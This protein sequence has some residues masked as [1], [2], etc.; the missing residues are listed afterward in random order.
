MAARTGPGNGMVMEG[1]PGK[2]QPPMKARSSSGT[3]SL[4]WLALSAPG[5]VAAYPT[6]SP[7]STS[8]AI[9]SIM[10]PFRRSKSTAESR[11]PGR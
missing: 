6:P 10:T 9:W 2:A 4:L 8:I 3:M 5:L 1:G 7:P 11:W